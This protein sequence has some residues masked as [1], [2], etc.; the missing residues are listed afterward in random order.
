MERLRS[1]LVW[2]ILYHA[3]QKSKFLDWTQIN[4]LTFRSS[5]HPALLPDS[6]DDMPKDIPKLAGLRNLD[7]IIIYEAPA[8]WLGNTPSNR[9]CRYGFRESHTT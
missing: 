6:L 5:H 1:P 8:A 7:Q 2:N 9:R 3:F 4:H